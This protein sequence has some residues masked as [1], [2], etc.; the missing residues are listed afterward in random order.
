MITLPFPPPV[1]N[2]FATVGK[3]RIRSRRYEEWIARAGIELM[4]QR[5]RPIAG[6]FKITLTYDRPDRRRRDLDGLQKAVLDLLV[7]HRVIEDDSLAQE[8][9]LRWGP[10]ATPAFVRAVLE[11]AEAV[12]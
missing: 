1:N 3:R 6:P 12:T 8:I 10:M 11:P 7:K 4:I 9:V 5:P 2:L